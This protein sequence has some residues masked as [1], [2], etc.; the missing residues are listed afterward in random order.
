MPAEAAEGKWH[1]TP[2]P[3]QLWRHRGRALL[4]A[5]TLRRKDCA[6]LN[7]RKF[8]HVLFIVI[9]I[10]FFITISITTIII[11]SIF[12]IIIILTIIILIIDI[13]SNIRLI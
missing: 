11:T 12:I 5:D 8:I 13:V 2:G 9:V 3:S 6:V 1:A 7:P 4:K 10:I